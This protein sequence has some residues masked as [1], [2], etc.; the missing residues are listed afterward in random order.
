MTDICHIKTGKLDEF[1]IKDRSNQECLSCHPDVAIF[2]FVG[3]LA[4]VQPV[5]IWL[6]FHLQVFEDV[7]LKQQHLKNIIHEIFLHENVA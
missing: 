1:W 7:F 4:T 6:V 5:A 2:T 3:E